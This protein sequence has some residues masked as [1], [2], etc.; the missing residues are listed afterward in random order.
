MKLEEVLAR[1]L[2]AE[3]ESE[4]DSLNALLRESAHA[5]QGADSYS[6][7]ARGSIL[8]DFYNGVE[9]VFVRVARELNGGIPQA[10]QWHRELVNNMALAIPEVRPALIDPPLAASLLEYLRFRHVFR[11]VY[12]TV[13]EADRMRS[14]EEKLPATLDAFRE[15]VS[16]FLHRMLGDADS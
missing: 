14:L 15:Q 12:G 16:A 8:H 2:A 6:R 10:E 11:N 3:I 7:R 5:P 9:R 1:R 4:L 13:L